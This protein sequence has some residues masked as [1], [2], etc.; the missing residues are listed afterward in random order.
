MVGVV[1]RIKSKGFSV[2][3]VREGS[4]KKSKVKFPEAI[5]AAELFK[6][7]GN[8]DMIIDKKD[9]KFLKGGFSQ[10]KVIGARI[11]VLPDG[12]K[13]NKA[14]S[15]FAP[16][17]TIHD[18]KSKSH[19]DAIFE[20]PNGK[21]AYLYTVN[22]MKLSKKAKYKRVAEFSKCLPKL[23]KNLMKA[24][25]S[26]ELVLP[27]LILLKTKM[28][29]GNEIY[30]LKNHHKGLTTLKKK[31]ISI[32]GNRIT[33]D[34]I[35]KDGVPQKITEEFSA[36]VVNKLKSVLKTKKSGNF[37]F[38]DPNG[39]PLKDIVFE[40]AFEKYCGKKFYPHIVRSHY[41]T[42]KAEKF[43]KGKR[44]ILKNEAEEFYLEI[45]R[46]LGHKKFSKKNGWE[47]SYQVTLHHYIQPELVEKI[48]K[49]IISDA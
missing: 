14:Y 32:S 47:D 49:L 6:S 7:H 23:K 3:E 11:D 19:W 39:H 46:K 34:Y 45:A 15:L 8:L 13:L 2:C 30:Y 10:G 48:E 21:F 44:K 38:V 31:N 42:D 25:D 9:S 22:K 28:R 40:Q 36:K 27:M 12:T 29:V 18:E 24:V 43:L 41:A 35:A 5:A 37:V 1:Y 16:K 33:F 17:L 4:C 26:D 20:N